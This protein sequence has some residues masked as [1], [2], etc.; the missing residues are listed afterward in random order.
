MKKIP[1]VVIR[2][3][4]NCFLDVMRCCGMAGIPVL[5]VV[6]TWEGA[7]PWYSE[8]SCHYSQP[9][10]IHNPGTSEANAAQEMI[11]LG[12]RLVAKYNRKLLLLPTS[13]TGLV[14]VQNHW[15]ELGKYF[16]LNGSQ[17]FGECLADIFQK[18][19]FYDIL[20]QAGIDV[21]AYRV[22]EK[23]TDIEDIVHSIKYPC[24]YK[25]TTKD[26]VQ[27][28]YQC[29]NK[30]KAIIN[31][32]ADELRGNLRREIQDGYKLVVQEYVDMQSPLD[33]V[34]SYMYCGESGEMLMTSSQITMR[35]HPDVFGTGY[36][37]KLEFNKE[38][39]EINAKIGKA[40]NWRG[41]MNIEYKF[42]HSDG[43][44]KV[45]EAN[46]RPWLSIYFQASQG[47]NYIEYLYQDAMGELD[48]R[49]LTQAS[50]EERESEVYRVNFS[51]F[52]NML[53]NQFQN[54]DDMLVYI[55][56]WF[57]HHQG[58]YVFT[59]FQSQDPNPGIKE[60][61]AM[62]QAENEP[63]KGILMLLLAFMRQ[64]SPRERGF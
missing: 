43:K 21:P 34:S 59:T 13:D 45:I 1:V 48:D 60:M 29:H 62:I 36:M 38:L 32:N 28:F 7:G 11:D 5:P 6:F 35:R 44:W 14:F 15:G 50:S 49:F 22:C 16:I 56:K 40:L 55:K 25:P 12:K 10:R 9:V 26:I 58:Q 53:K 18:D 17:D 19:V 63:L 27:S 51:V 52:W 8:H 23:M 4:D 64:S 61:E 30:L 54:L 3:N 24:I 37:S 2:S 39:S 33:E 46:L 41:L 42:D 31:K 20:T 57:E 47:Y